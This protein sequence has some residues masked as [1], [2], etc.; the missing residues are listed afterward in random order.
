MN[1]TYNLTMRIYD[2]QTGG[3]PKWTEIHQDIQ[4]SNGIFQVLLGDVTTL[5]LPFDTDYWVSVE[6][7]TD[8]EMTPR[9][10]LAS[11]GYAYKAEHAVIADNLTIP[12]LPSGV[13]VMWSGAIVDIP[14][15]WALCDGTNGTPDLRDRFI[16]GASQDDG[17]IAKTTVKGS[18]QQIGGEHEHTLTE[19][20]LASHHHT[21]YASST[22]GGGSQIVADSGGGS[23]SVYNENTSNTG[24][25]AAHENCPPFYALAFI[26]KL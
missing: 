15:G 4:I 8:G 22:T 20:E 18:L 11:V 5:D 19:N 3:T 17:P 1:G 26:M 23:D 6:I 25:D 2:A 9:T 10:R 24:S 16:V 7:D 12:E 13:I 21:V 14:E